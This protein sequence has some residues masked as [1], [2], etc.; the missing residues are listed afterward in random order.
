[1]GQEIR[2]VKICLEIKWQADIYIWYEIFVWLLTLTNVMMLGNFGVVGDEF[3]TPSMC[4]RGYYAV[5]D[6]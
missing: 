3:Q 6:C 1:M 5:L 2:Y 4:S